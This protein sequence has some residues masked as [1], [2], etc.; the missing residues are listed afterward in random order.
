MKNLTINS[1][2]SGGLITNYYCS[3]ECKHCLYACSP[4]RKKEYINRATV[5]SNAGII[6]SLGCYSVHIGGGEPMLHTEK[7][8][9]T[10]RTL[11]NEGIGVEY[12]ETN[13]SWYK[14]KKSAV[15]VLKHLKEA[16]LQ[17]LLVSISPF[18]NEFIPFEKVKGVMS[19]CRKVGISIFPWI[20]DFYSDIDAFNDKQTFSLKAYQMRYGE[21]YIREIPQ[22]YWI[23][24]GG[25][26]AY[27]Y[28]T[29]FAKQSLDALLNHS[30]GCHE[31]T[32]T[33]HF[34]IDLYGNY[35]PGLCTG[36]SIEGKDL[37]KPL[38]K[39]K[40]PLIIAL[41]NHGIKGLYQIASNQYGF[42]ARDTY[43]NKCHLCLEIRKHLV[44]MKKEVNT[45][46][47]PVEMYD[48]L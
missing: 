47:H 34:H 30:V 3:S 42:E 13:S 29:I 26:A 5:Q 35:I 46:L 2:Q 4:K 14:D 12:V 21:N 33:T 20:Q 44:K 8:H 1:L 37:G 15:N 7:L 27:T 41:Y 16:G 31:L 6:A 45:E 11:Q 19:A 28:Q 38:D 39:D 23:H 25:R 36:I 22:R 48:H 10:L 17:T 24:F 18:H 40:Y 9:D 32:D 43:F